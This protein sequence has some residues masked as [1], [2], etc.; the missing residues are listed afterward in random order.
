MLSP[1]LSF[2]CPTCGEY[3]SKAICSAGKLWVPHHS[4]GVEPKC[5]RTVRID[6]PEV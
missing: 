6:S 3:S 5:V 4:L 1:A 2:C